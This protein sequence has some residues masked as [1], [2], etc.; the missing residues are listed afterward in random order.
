MKLGANGGLYV[1]DRVGC[2]GYKNWGQVFL[3]KVISP[4]NTLRHPRGY[5]TQQTTKACNTRTEVQRSLNF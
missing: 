2:G 5:N 4:A 1:T 3:D